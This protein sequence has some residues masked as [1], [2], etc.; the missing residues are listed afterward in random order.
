MNVN[1]KNSILSGNEKDK[2]CLHHEAHQAARIFDFSALSQTPAKTR[3]PQTVD[4]SIAL[5]ACIPC[6]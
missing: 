5:C 3:R 2:V 4:Q 1:A 6:K